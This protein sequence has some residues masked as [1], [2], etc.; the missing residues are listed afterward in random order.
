MNDLDARVPFLTAAARKHGHRHVVACISCARAPNI[1][2]RQVEITYA[3]A[4]PKRRRLCGKQGPLTLSTKNRSRVP[5]MKS[6]PIWQVEAPTRHRRDAHILRGFAGKSGHLL[7]DTSLETIEKAL[8]RFQRW[9]DPFLLVPF[10]C[11]SYDLLIVSF[12]FPICFRAVPH[13]SL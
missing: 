5:Q 12:N 10:H 8:A 4:L 1:L 2:K 13:K 9:L 6:L 3:H 7:K 11:R